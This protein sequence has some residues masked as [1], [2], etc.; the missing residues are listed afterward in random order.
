MKQRVISAVIAFLIVIPLLII[1]GYAYKI[2]VIALGV[3]AL[4][5]AIKA[6]SNKKD[7]P[8]LVKILAIFTFVLT[9][10]V[11]I[12][13]NFVLNIDYKYLILNALLMF[14]PLI[15]Y[16]D[17]KKYGLED[18]TYMFAFST[19]L[20]L[21][22]SALMMI[23]EFNVYYLIFLLTVTI[24]SD[25]FAYFVGTLIGKHKMCP[26]ISP[27]KSIEGFV[28]GLLFGTFITTSIYYV[29]F[30]YTGSLVWLIL[31]V[32]LLSVV[33]TLGDLFF[34]FIKRHYDIKDFGNIMPGH[35]GVLDRLDSLLF[36]LLTFCLIISII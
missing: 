28:G 10:L 21:G 22:F 12:N 9:M 14:L 18:A 19:F 3:I 23:R 15:I 32:M 4:F 8:L 13:N 29:T 6:R 7:I 17:D 36:V 5:E 20:L 1:G 35:G 26:T 2:G 24:T 33:S 25:T 27:N 16:N 11:N 31:L 30:E 34:S